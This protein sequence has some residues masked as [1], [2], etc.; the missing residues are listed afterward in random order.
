MDER[1]KYIRYDCELIIAVT[2]EKEKVLEA[3]GTCLNL[4]QGGIKFYSAAD[5][6]VDTKCKIAFDYKDSYHYLHG[7]ILYKKNN[8]SKKIFEYGLEFD[9]KLSQKELEHLLKLN[10]H[11][12]TN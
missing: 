3:N 2:I 7:I 5:F 4:S 1:R 10:E 11:K 8:K 6:P 9:V 12:Y